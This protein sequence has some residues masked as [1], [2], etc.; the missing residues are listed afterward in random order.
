MHQIMVDNQNLHERLQRME[1]E[2]PK[3]KRKNTLLGSI[4]HQEEEVVTPVQSIL[5]PPKPETFSGKRGEVNVKDW[6]FALR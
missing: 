4:R 1:S 6:L 3:E 2:A 5:K